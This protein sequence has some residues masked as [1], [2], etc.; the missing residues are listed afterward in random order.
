MKC[1]DC[2][3]LLEEYI[4]GEAIETDAEQINT[5]LITCAACNSEFE[6]LR[7]EQEVFAR[8]DRE[9]NISPAMWSAIQER[10]AA[11]RHIAQSSQFNPRAWLAG[12]FTAPRF[13]LAFSGAMA[14]LIAAIVIGV[15]YL[16][17]QPQ[18]SAPQ[19]VVRTITPGP[20]PPP[21]IYATS[22]SS[23][24]KSNVNEIVTSQYVGPVNAPA[25]SNVAMVKTSSVT[26]QNDVLF[27]DIAYSDIENKDTADHIAQA[28]NLLR[29]IRSIHLAGE[30][31]EVDVTYEKSMS[32]RL[33]DENVVLRRDAETSGKY[34]VKALLGDLEPFLIDIANLPD[35]TT[36][37][38]LRAINDRVQKTEIVAAL[39]S[40]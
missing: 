18:P 22:P 39:Q 12:L 25:K 24:V 34:P 11:E 28:Q 31:D 15:M 26:D 29:T 7:A 21:P 6:A 3:N 20:I 10:T 1:D 9:L 4:D 37:S 30:N 32:R 19:A 27:S 14:V 17:T 2:L 38:E 23:P 35:K 13:G 33:L 16:R 8:Y 36:Q 5:H 40:Y